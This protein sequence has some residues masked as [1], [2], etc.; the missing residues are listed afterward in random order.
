MGYEGQEF[1]LEPVGR[2]GV[3]PRR[4]FIGQKLGAFALNQFAF[5]NIGDR[6]TVDDGPRFRVFD[7]NA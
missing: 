7:R 1:V 3:S 2:F 5:G 6:Q 4:S